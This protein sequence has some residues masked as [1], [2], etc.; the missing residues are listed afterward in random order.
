MHDDEERRED[1]RRVEICASA[2][3]CISVKEK[4]CDKLCVIQKGIWKVYV[5]R[6]YRFHYYSFR[7][8]KW[9]TD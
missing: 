9:R 2:C 7:E 5:T 1:R 8:Q 3:A 6:F 4:G